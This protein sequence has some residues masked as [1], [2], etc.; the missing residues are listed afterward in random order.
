MTEFRDAGQDLIGG[1]GPHERPWIAVAGLQVLLD[2]TL[3][4]GRAAMHS[5]AELLL[6]E[7]REPALDLV[8]PRGTGRRE[9]QVEARVSQ[10]PTMDHLGLVRAVVVHDQVHVEVGGHLAVDKI[11]ELAELAGSVAAMAGSDHLSSRNIQRREQRR[12]AVAHV[13]MRSALDLAGSHGKQGLGAIESLD[14]RLLVDAQDQR[15]LRRSQV[16]AHDV[17]DF[18]DEERIAG[19]FEGLR[20]MRFEAECAPDSSDGHVAHADALGH[21]AR[22]PMRGRLGLTL[23][24]GRDG[25]F[26]LSVADLAWGTRTGLFQEPVDALLLEASAP[27]ANSQ[28]IAA[29]G[30]GDLAVMSALGAP[31]DDPCALRQRLRSRRTARVAH[32][33]LALRR[34]EDHRLRSLSAHRRSPPQSTTETN[35]NCLRISGTG[36]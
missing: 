32:Q 9:V 31:K 20:P 6:G 33:G 1:L 12:S 10:H 2:R 18:L 13:V 22:A 5:P 15:S 25:A 28:P 3:E 16:Q 26:D 30:A 35:T 17:A 21:G 14:L 8:D 7:V 4:R 29:D 11:E 36:H 24:R 19:K 34:C 23:E 27:L